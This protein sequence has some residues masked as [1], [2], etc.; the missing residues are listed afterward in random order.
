MKNK[1]LGLALVACFSTVALSSCGSNKWLTKSDKVVVT[2]DGTE[3]TTEDLFG[4][5]ATSNA[6]GVAAYYNAISEVI[7][8]NA[9]RSYAESTELKKRSTLPLT[10]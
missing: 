8:R 7:V 3:Y 6:T 10:N 9:T 5:L 1:L 2:I 4:Q